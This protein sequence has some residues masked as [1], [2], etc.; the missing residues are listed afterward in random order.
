MRGINYADI[1]SDNSSDDDED[2]A[3]TVSNE[4]D[5]A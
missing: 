3:L 2:M 1:N 4:D 5:L